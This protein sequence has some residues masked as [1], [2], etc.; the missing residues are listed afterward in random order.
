MRDHLRRGRDQIELQIRFRLGCTFRDRSRVVREARLLDV[1][2]RVSVHLAL[3]EQIADG[4]AALRER[5]DARQAGLV[6]RIADRA[7]SICGRRGQR[8]LDVEIGSA[9]ALGEAGCLEGLVALAL[10]ELLADR[11]ATL[12]LIATAAGHLLLDARSLFGQLVHLDE[13]LID[14]LLQRGRQF[15]AGLGLAKRFLGDR[16]HL[17]DGFAVRGLDFGCELFGGLLTA[18]VRLVRCLEGNA[19]QKAVGVCETGDA[20][21]GAAGQGSVLE[22]RHGNLLTWGKWPSGR[23]SAQECEPVVLRFGRFPL[24]LQV[25]ARGTLRL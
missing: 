9:G 14:R 17:V 20:R 15:F 24:P 8:R 11:L 18:A 1:L 6:H 12:V 7:G 5:H 19:G 25:D 2:Q 21:Q 10:D 4:H 22:F 13:G 16:L 23:E 3:G